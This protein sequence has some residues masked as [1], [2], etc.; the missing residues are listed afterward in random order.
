MNKGFRYAVVFYFFIN[1]I[2]LWALDPEYS[3][4]QY[5]QTQWTLD[6]G[7]PGNTITDITQ[8]ADG[9]LWIGFPRSVYRFDGMK[10]TPLSIFDEQSAGYREITCLESTRKGQLWIGTRGTGLWR[11]KYEEKKYKQFT[12][13]KG[14]AGEN[15]RCIVADHL[16]SLWIG[17]DGNINVMKDKD[18]TRYG[19][20]SGL[21][22]QKINV[23][24]E[25]SQGKIWLG[26][27]R[28]GLLKFQNGSAVNIP[29]GNFENLDVR[30]MSED[31]QGN[32]WLGT[33]R[34]LIRF[35]EAAKSSRTFDESDG[36]SHH[37]INVVAHD[38]DGNLWIG[39]ANGLDRYTG[40]S[41]GAHS[42]FERSLQETWVKAIFEDREKNLWIGTDGK[43]LIQLRE[44]RLKLYSKR[45]GLPNDY[46]TSLYEDSRQT[47]WVGST[48]GLSRFSK[49]DIK[50]ANLKQ[51]YTGS[52]V[53]SICLGPDGDV[54][55][56]TFGDGL[57]RVRQNGSIQKYS[58]SQ[59]LLSDSI[60]AL[61]L[62]NN[63][64]L[65][66]GTDNGLN[67]YSDGKFQSFTTANGLH[68][69]IVYYIYQDRNHHVWVIYD[70]RFDRFDGQTWQAPEAGIFPKGLVVSDIFEDADGR[71][72]IATK[73]NGLLLYN[74]ESLTSLTRT[75]GLPDNY[76][77]KIFL[78]TED[79]FW[80]T[81]K[82]GI[83]K[84]AR[85]DLLDLA[86]GA[87][88]Q[89]ALFHYGRHEGLKGSEV[90]V[91]S[92]Y[93]S[94]MT[95]NNRIL[96]GTKNGIASLDLTN[97]KISDHEPP[98]IIANV[99]INRNTP[100]FSVDAGSLV[101]IR[102]L[103]FY[104]TSPTFR[105]PE[106]IQFSYTL[107]G[108]DTN[109][110]FP[111]PGSQRTARYTNLSPG[112]YTFRVKA[113]NGYGVWNH[114]GSSVTFTLKP[115]FVQTWLFKF[116]ILTVVILMVLGI[117]FLVTR[118]DLFKKEKYKS[119]TLDSTRAEQYLKKLTYL[120]EVEKV[121]RDES[122]SLQTLADQLSVSNYHLSQLIN[123]SLHKSFFD[124]VN[125]YR[126]E[127]AK[128]K[129]GNF[130]DNQTILGIGFEVGFNSKSAFN[131]VFKKY[132]TMTPSQ[133][134]KKHKEQKR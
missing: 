91:W 97:L 83:F 2:F 25:D 48:G 65:W 33:N 37:I 36:L 43:G 84:V 77:H 93:S 103:S 73:G 80:M 16:G 51:L 116:L 117:Y 3:V 52:I 71:V 113:R 18:I 46:I 75:H 21:P 121:Y 123:E 122:L 131:R 134:R 112:Y 105:N 101:G 82:S 22:P 41:R 53:S 35:N 44:G 55:F 1:G 40:E 6:N 28:H 124:L 15:I 111:D 106:R 57:F 17:F 45:N 7:L 42:P 129:L 58:T 89:P 14:I 88:T 13:Q 74:K 4:H 87:I 125:G 102:E 110:I 62:D 68:G 79:N 81:G 23:V 95:A 100:L 86:S 63:G 70:K 60:L 10:F 12:P 39:S 49:G 99:L 109:W 50:A 69:T 20:A 85:K 31:P 126:V 61:L 76:I 26:T 127:E 115:L 56:A 96:M 59:G 32:L 38:S 30:T 118:T 128:E 119:S 19:E 98:V 104:F 9:F 64:A 66:I 54:W 107:E 29:L 34:G 72:W 120:M 47:L 8:T 5:I 78:D 114:K 90:T 11:Y 130:K 92:H 108:F 27:H 67:K 24:F 132:T 94:I 133:Y